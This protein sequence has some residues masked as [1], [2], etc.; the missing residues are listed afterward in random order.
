MKE[1]Y[2]FTHDY[3]A[4]ND[5][6]LLDVLSGWGHEGLGIFW[7]LIELSYEEGG[8]LEVAKIKSYANA[9]RTTS[10]NINRIIDDFDL[11]K[12]DDIYFWSDSVL[13]RLNIRNKKSTKAKKSAEIRWKNANAL[14]TQSDRNARKERKGKE[15]KG[16]KK[17]IIHEESSLFEKFWELYP[18]QRR[19]DKNLALKAYLKVLEDKR[20]TEQ[21]LLKAIEVYAVCDEVKKGFASGCQAWLNQ[22]KFLNIY[23]SAGGDPQTLK[24]DLDEELR[25][26]RQ[27][28]GLDW[29]DSRGNK[30]AGLLDPVED[31]EKYKKAELVFEQEEKR[32]RNQYK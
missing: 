32:I 24:P 3:N 1:T 6:K 4:R 17:K 27:R 11:F 19:G 25:K 20:A 26:Q 10:E 30:Q 31:E 9:L 16:N 22:S 28:L 23:H 14:R 5:T 2:Y 21:E 13:S 15:K 7:C 8:K 18:R 12:K 29:V